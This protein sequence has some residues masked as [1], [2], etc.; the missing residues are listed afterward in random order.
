MN[1]SLYVPLNFVKDKNSVEQLNMYPD[2]IVLHGSFKWLQDSNIEL[3][4]G[5]NNI[6]A[7][8]IICNSAG[9]GVSLDGHFSKSVLDANMIN[10]VKLIEALVKEGKKMPAILIH[11]AQSFEIDSVKCHG[12]ME[13]LDNKLRDLSEQPRIDITYRDPEWF[14]DLCSISTRYSESLKGLAEC[15]KLFKF[16]ITLDVPANA[17]EQKVHDYIESVSG[18]TTDVE[19]VISTSMGDYNLKNRLEL[20]K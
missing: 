11:G 9:K 19:Y 6:K 1:I 18:I 7:L 16:G 17:D 8:D 3:L 13:V 15:S 4:S 5:L 2:G 12:I 20:I 14:C 10:V